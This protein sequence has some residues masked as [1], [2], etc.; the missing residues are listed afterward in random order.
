MA[1]NT[2][3][4]IDKA[5]QAL[6]GALDMEE[7]G[8]EIQLPEQVVDFESNVELTETPDGGAEVNFDPNAPVDKSQIPFDGNLADYVDESK[9]G[10]F[11]S[12][13]LAAFEADREN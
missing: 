3:N 12:D 8:Q 5:M 7:V 6:Q 10:K 9:L 1:K 4:N 2:K 13:L 11:S